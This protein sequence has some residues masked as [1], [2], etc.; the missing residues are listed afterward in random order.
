LNVLDALGDDFGIHV[1]VEEV[2]KV[3]FDGEGLRT[4]IN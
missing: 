4:T 1:I 2:V 3:A